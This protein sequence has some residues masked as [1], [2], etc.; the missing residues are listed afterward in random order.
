MAITIPLA[1]PRR[2][3]SPIHGL[4]NTLGDAT[5]RALVQLKNPVASGV[6]LYIYELRIGGTWNVSDRKRMRHTSSPLTLAGTTTT[7]LR[8]RMN[9]NDATAIQATLN[10]CTACATQPPFNESDSFFYDLLGRDTA[11]GY[12]QIPILVPGSYPIIV[13]QGSALEFCTNAADSSA[14]EVRVYAVWD[15]HAA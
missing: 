7:G 1:D 4:V 8:Q 12:Q 3:V 15:E 13:K 6:L 14:K 5:H 10:G 2:P 9:E 11:A